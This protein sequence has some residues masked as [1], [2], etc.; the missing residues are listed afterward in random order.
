MLYNSTNFFYQ[1]IFMLYSCYFKVN[2]VE[3]NAY[4]KIVAYAII[5]CIIS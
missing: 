5:V 3:M 2:C 4:V 1:Y